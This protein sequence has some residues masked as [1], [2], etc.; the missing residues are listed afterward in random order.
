MAAVDTGILVVVHGDYGDPLVAAAEALVGPLGLHVTT[1]CP[2]ADPAVVRR[3]VARGIERQ[4][5]GG[6][7]L[8]LTD[9]CGSTPANVCQQ[10]VGARA[11]CEMLTGLNLPMLLK[12]ATCDRK[13]G[14]RQLAVELEQSSRRSITSL[15][16][17]SGHDRERGC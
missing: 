14:A 15:S 17:R 8:V 12:L 1:V 6:G 7:V 13:A 2:E 5:R 4:D 11:D 3:R 10:L 16:S 9:L